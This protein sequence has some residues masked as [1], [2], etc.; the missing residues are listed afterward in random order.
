MLKKVIPILFLAAL[1]GAG[2][3]YRSEIKSFFIKDSRTTNVVQKTILI[4]G[5]LDMTRLGEILE[6]EGVVKKKEL[7]YQKAK[8]E[9]LMEEALSP[10]KYLILPQTQMTNLIRGF[11]V[12]S[13]GHG[14]SELKVNVVF[15]LC[16][17]INDMAKNISK[18]I[19][20][21]SASIVDY[22]SS[23]DF[24]SSRAVTLEQLPALF[25]PG[26]YQMYYDTDAQDFTK[27]MLKIYDGFW[28]EERNDKLKSI[29]LNQ[30]D[31]ITLASVVYSEQSKMSEEWPQIAGLYLNRLKKGM[32][33]Q[34]DPTFK[35]CW[36]D[37]LVGVEHLTFKHRDI[38]CPYNTYKYEGLPPGPI[39]LVPSGV[40]DAVLNASHHDYLFMVAKPGGNGHN[41]SKNLRDHDRYVAEYKK[42]LKEYLKN[43][44]NS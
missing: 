21:D 44:R 22:V 36:G 9:G 42:W 14:A 39:C 28:T 26:T 43:N 5:Y 24:L 25:L 33:L 37:K 10:G 34:S 19:Q 41:F 4:R 6:E 29:S 40:V 31:A 15:N 20:A 8:E 12:D 23:V 38:D 11:I 18:C 27:N 1:V 2:Y 17:D 16:R 3:Y 30:I 7:I 35:F 32:L 13:T